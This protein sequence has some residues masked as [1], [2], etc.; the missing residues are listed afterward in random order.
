MVDEWNFRI[1]IYLLISSLSEWNFKL[2][3]SLS[4]SDKNWGSPSFF[5]GGYYEIKRK[6]ESATIFI[7]NLLVS[8]ENILYDISEYIL[9]DIGLFVSHDNILYVV[10]SGIFMSHQILFYV[11]SEY[12][13]G[14]TRGHS[15]SH[16]ILF[17]VTLEDII[18]HAKRYFMS[19]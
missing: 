4:Y 5:N 9:E 10:I 1:N 16:W 17:H 18:C 19:N 8:H 11:T 14:H 13:W 7:K 3:G 15:M 12:L 6:N 2:Y